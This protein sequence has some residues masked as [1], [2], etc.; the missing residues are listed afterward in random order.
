M[1]PLSA[2]LVILIIIQVQAQDEKP[3]KLTIDVTNELTGQTVDAELSFPGEPIVRLDKGRYQLTLKPGDNEMLT[4]S[5][6]G[7]FD[8]EIRLDYEEERRSASREVK[9]QPGIPQLHITILDQETEETITS[10][11]DLFTLDESSVVFS[12]EVEVAPYTI[13]LEYNKAHVLQ[14]R[15]HGYFS[16]KDTID[17][18]N[19]F[20]GRVRERE[21]KLVPLKAGNKIS[22]NNIYF[23]ENEATLTE[24]AKTMLVELTH[25]LELQPGLV[26]EIGAYT[27][28]HGTDEY[29]LS[30]SGKRAAAVKQY[31]IEKGAA[32]KQIHTK[33]YGEVF[34]VAPNDTPENRAL[35]RRVEFKIVSVG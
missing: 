15:A 16:F 23:E 25:V 1:K 19:V 12:E 33:G 14:V 17:F 27:D 32:D 31:L 20:D 34:P 22:L 2:L 7:Y 4:V 9:L 24:F 5:R 35:N 26:I 28:D 10:D 8:S 13:D 18:T 30:L 11:I 21:I 29:N 3:L 6:N